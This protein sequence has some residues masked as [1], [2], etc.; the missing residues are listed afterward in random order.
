MDDTEIHLHDTKNS[1]ALFIM[2]LKE[3]NET[4]N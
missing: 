2:I 3:K 4:I 1:Y